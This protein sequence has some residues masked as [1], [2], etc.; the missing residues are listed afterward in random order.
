[1]LPVTLPSAS[2]VT[3]VWR[4]IDP[5]SLLVPN[6]SRQPR[7]PRSYGPRLPYADDSN[8]S[9]GTRPYRATLTARVVRPMSGARLATA[10]SACRLPRDVAAAIRR[11][12]SWRRLRAPCPREPAT[13]LATSSSG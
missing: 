9:Q 4:L 6:G 3:H 5:A 2:R 13:R 8:L 11:P 10:P 1:V 12:L 7:P